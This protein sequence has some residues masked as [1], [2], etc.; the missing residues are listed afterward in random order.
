MKKKSLRT[1][2]LLTA[3]VSCF[4]IPNTVSAAKVKK[5]HIMVY[6]MTGRTLKYKKIVG[7]WEDAPD[8]PKAGGKMKKI[9]CAKKC[10]YY[11]YKTDVMKHKKVSKKTFRKRI[12]YSFN[13]WQDE[14]MR[15]AGNKLCKNSFQYCTVWIK[16][17]KIIKIMGEYLP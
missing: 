2:I 5:T 4:F 13:V 1:I 9:T 15:G 7:Y 10:K 8:V 11:W 17:K 12:K 3:I 6:K 16:N 14:F